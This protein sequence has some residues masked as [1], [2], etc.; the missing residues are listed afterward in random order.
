MGLLSGEAAYKNYNAHYIPVAPTEDSFDCQYY[1]PCLADQ[2]PICDEL[3]VF[4][5]SQ[6][7]PR[8]WVELQVEHPAMD[9]EEDQLK[10]YEQLAQLFDGQ[11]RMDKPVRQAMVGAPSVIGG[12]PAQ[13]S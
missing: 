12:V 1:Y 8:Y 3:V 2:A 13:A 9:L 10:M 5:P 7:L 6:A 11:G 4:Q